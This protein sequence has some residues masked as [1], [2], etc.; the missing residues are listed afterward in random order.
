LVRAHRHLEGFAR[1]I[2]QPATAGA[3]DSRAAQRFAVAAAVTHAQS[4]VLPQFSGGAEATGRVHVSTEA[5]S[6]DGTHAGSSTKQFDFG[7]SLGGA[8]HQPSRFGLS[9]HRL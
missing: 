9:L 8:Q 4:T 7:E 1:D 5:T 6:T 3:V 2:L